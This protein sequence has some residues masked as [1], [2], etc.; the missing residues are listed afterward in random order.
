MLSKALPSELNE[1]VSPA[2]ASIQSATSCASASRAIS[3][4]VRGLSGLTWH[5][6]IE[7]EMRSR[8]QSRERIYTVT[9][10]PAF[11]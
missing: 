2:C 7:S 8:A 6:R 9:R 5:C 10:S 3:S 1:S 11:R 4:G